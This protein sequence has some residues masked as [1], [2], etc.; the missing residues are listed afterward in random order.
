MPMF[1]ITPPYDDVLGSGRTALHILSL[2]MTWSLALT[3]HPSHTTPT[4]NPTAQWIECG[5]T[6]QPD[7]LRKKKISAS[8][9]D[10][11]QIPPVPRSQPSCK[12]D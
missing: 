3:S 11:T 1:N 12:T 5:R 2:S 8:T 10:E 9:G 7:T 6:P 4:D